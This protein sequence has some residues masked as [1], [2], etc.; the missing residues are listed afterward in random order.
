M[1]MRA[2]VLISFLS[3]S[4][5]AFAQQ[6]DVCP[7][8]LVSIEPGGTVSNGSKDI[9]I[10]AV[11]AGFPIRVGWSLDF[12]KDG[13][14]ELVHFADAI[15]L[16]EF[17]GEIFAQINEIQRQAP[18]RGKR[19]IDLGEKPLRWTGLLGTNGFLEHR[20]NDDQPASQLPVKSQWCLDSRVPRSEWP[21]ELRSKSASK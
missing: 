21:E 15:F 16:T 14:A 5:A 19:R 17:E 13:K 6:L 18:L 12:D 7:G 1:F 4:M 3:I 8:H 9:L 10:K 2:F 11:R 20:F